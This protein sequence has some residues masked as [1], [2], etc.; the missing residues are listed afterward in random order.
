MSSFIVAIE[1]LKRFF[2]LWAWV[3]MFR[4]HGA[5]SSSEGDVDGARRR[6]NCLGVLGALGVEVAFFLVAGLV[7]GLG[8]AL[9]LRGFAATGAFL[10]GML[11]LARAVQGIECES[12]ELM[13]EPL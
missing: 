2:S 4:S 12:L 11:R 8:A 10:G 7:V 3:V 5:T 1:S 13:N 9:V 6:F